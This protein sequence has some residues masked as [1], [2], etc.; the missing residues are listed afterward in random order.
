MQLQEHGGRRGLRDEA[1]IESALGRPRNKFAHDSTVDIADLTAAAAF[2]IAT[3]HPYVDGNKRTAT[4]VALI[5]LDLDG[6]DLNRSNNE[7]EDTI[8]ALTKGDIT[9][10]AL[11]EWIRDALA[12]LPFHGP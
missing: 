11:A 8:L 3:S 1:V 7:V 4:V 10:R 6:Y 2:T 5:F 12:P 9:E